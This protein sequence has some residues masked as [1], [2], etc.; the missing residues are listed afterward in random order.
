MC[1]I[2]RND[3]GG[4]MRPVESLLLLRFKPIHG[5]ADLILIC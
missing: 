2:V 3:S 1:W 5:E 4:E